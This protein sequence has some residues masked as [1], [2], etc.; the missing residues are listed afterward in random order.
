M[1]C[2]R[3]S[4]SVWHRTYCGKEPTE[5]V[6]GTELCRRHA[7]AQRGANTA[8]ARRNEEAQ[9]QRAI[10][11]EWRRRAKIAADAIGITTR[12]HYSFNTRQLDGQI[13]ISLEDFERIADAYIGKKAAMN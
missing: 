12:L 8:K 5:I 10:E 9:K 1:G 13:V 4:G 11:E 6:D 3:P 7:A 2:K